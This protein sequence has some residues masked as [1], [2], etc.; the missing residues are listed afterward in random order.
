MLVVLRLLVMLRLLVVFGAVV[1]RQWCYLRVVLRGRLQPRVE[2]PKL[3]AF[4]A[5]S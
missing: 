5:P 1:L 4:G 2:L 3:S